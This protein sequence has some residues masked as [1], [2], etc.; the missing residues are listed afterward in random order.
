MVG[1]AKLD[2]PPTEAAGVWADEESAVVVASRKVIESLAMFKVGLF[3]ICPF[4]TSSGCANPRTAL[5][6]RPVASE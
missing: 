3:L 2:P 5:V 6:T 4:P 1:L